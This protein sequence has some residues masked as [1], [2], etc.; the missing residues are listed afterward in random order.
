MNRSGP[1]AEVVAA[2]PASLL[3]SARQ[4]NDNLQRPDYDR[5]TECDRPSDRYFLPCDRLRPLLRPPMRPICD[6]LRPGCVPSPPYPPR[7][8]NPRNGPWTALLGCSRKEGTE[9]EVE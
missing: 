9:M 3:T 2:L 7:G 8:R 4:P 5:K 6:R 1:K